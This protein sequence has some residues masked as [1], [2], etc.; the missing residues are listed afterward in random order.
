MSVPDL[1]PATPP[2]REGLTHLLDAEISRVQA[3]EQ[4]SGLNLWGLFAAGAAMIWMLIGLLEAGGIRLR[5]LAQWTVVFGIAVHALRGVHAIAGRHT[6]LRSDTRYNVGRQFKGMRGDVFLDFVQNLSF[7]V[8]AVYA[9]QGV[10]LTS[11]VA[12][13]I[14]FAVLVLASGLFL[15]MTGTDFPVPVSRQNPFWV[16]AGWFG[17]G[18]FLLIPLI[19]A[20]GYAGAAVLAFGH[21]GWSELKVALLGVAIWEV[22]RVARQ[23]ARAPAQ[24]GTLTMIRRTFSLGRLSLNDAAEMVDITLGGLRASDILSERV[25]ELAAIGLELDRLAPELELINAGDA[26][27]AQAF[28]SEL[29]ALLARTKT[30]SRKAAEHMSVVATVIPAARRNGADALASVEQQAEGVRSRIEECLTRLN[31]VGESHLPEL[32]EDSPAD[33]T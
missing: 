8:L 12:A 3:E 4:R 33:G 24:L 26:E 11:V 20:P 23:I 5:P 32:A 14:H 10:W 6:D 21:G 29:L 17:V 2:T 27:R 30:V 31:K 15:L 18:L 19:A 28:R 7:A 13:V 16:R 25:E 9:G 1:S 22:T